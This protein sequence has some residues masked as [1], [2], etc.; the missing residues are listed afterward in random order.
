M[1]NLPCFD[2]RSRQREY[3]CNGFATI[4]SQFHA[5][6]KFDE[7]RKTKARANAGAGLTECSWHAIPHGVS[8]TF[9]RLFPNFEKEQVGPNKDKHLS[10]SNVDHELYESALSNFSH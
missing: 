10:F 9:I 5:Q 8:I 1:T 3:I 7:Q 2:K 6:K 4:S